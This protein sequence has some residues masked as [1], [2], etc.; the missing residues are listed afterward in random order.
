MVL[1]TLMRRLPMAIMLALPLVIIL[2]LVA[3]TPT[4]VSALAATQQETVI[5]A[6]PG[7]RTTRNS[8]SGS[9]SLTVSGTGTAASIT[10]YTTDAFYVFR[11][12]SR[13]ITPEHN[14]GVGL[15]INSQPVE[16]YTTIP[17]YS[18]SHTYQFTIDLG[19]NSQQLTFG[20]CDRVSG[21]LTITVTASVEEPSPP[22][23]ANLLRDPGFEEGPPRVLL[24][25]DTTPWAGEEEGAAVIMQGDAHTG[26]HFLRMTVSTDELNQA[27]V[28]NRFRAKPNTNYTVTFWTRGTANASITASARARFLG[29]CR[30][31][32]PDGTDICPDNDG[33]ED[34]DLGPVPPD[35]PKLALAEIDVPGTGADV[36]TPVSFTFNSGQYTELAVVFF[37]VFQAG[38]I[39]VDDVSVVEQ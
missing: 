37:G 20:T 27:F 36:W 30:T 22:P 7:P 35:Y 33:D 32:G 14:M 39:D 12:A 2:P 13:P 28:F 21:I 1:S 8:Y 31:A 38:H 16:D 11:R 23:S 19:G 9:V 15:C 29:D 6:L 34:L 25:T 18:S 3:L 4:G 10:G 26:S 17:P 5:V 24:P